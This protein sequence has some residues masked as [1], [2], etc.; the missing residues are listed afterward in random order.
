METK[1]K[2]GHISPRWTENI[3]YTD[4]LEFRKSPVTLNQGSQFANRN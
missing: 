2:E 1:K 3:A 4:A